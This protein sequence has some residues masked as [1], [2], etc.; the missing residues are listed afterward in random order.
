MFKHNSI[1]EE[2]TSDLTS[3]SMLEAES[4]TRNV[5]DHILTRIYRTMGGTSAALAIATP[6][7]VLAKRPAINSHRLLKNQATN[8][9]TNE[10]K[11]EK[12]NVQCCFQILSDR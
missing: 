10:R 2:S 4:Y 7:T 5:A 11:N 9:P 8:C 12:D 6:T 3:E 1:F